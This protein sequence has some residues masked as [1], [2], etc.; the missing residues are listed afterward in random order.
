MTGI[1][2]QHL[3]SFAARFQTAGYA[4]LV[5]DN[6]NFGA[7]DGVPRFEVDA[8]K[9]IEDYHDAITFATSL[10]G[11]VDPSR[12]AL[13]GS[14]YSGGNVLQASAVDRR[15]KAVIAQV[16]FVS[17]NSNAPGIMP[18]M[19]A[20]MADRARIATGQAGELTT[21]VPET[22]EEAE[23]GGSLSILPTPDAY[24]FFVHSPLP[25]GVTWENKI[26]LQSLFK[27]LKNEP[28]AYVPR[29][30]PT[31]LLMVVAE[32][33]LAV[34]V[35][36]QLAVFGEAGEPKELLFMPKTG[37]FDVYSGPAFEVNIEKQ[38]EFLKQWLV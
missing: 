12:I 14:S 35:P 26:T 3:G 7:S 17:G 27:L 33:D 5:Y 1:K 10:A 4:A 6:R 38:L 34:H 16:P 9:Q 21:V 8:F 2:E 11:E 13:W 18:A 25:E 36:T 15:V 28:R 29:I 31:P 32:L 20:I 22:R 30:S 24:D 19:G 37:H 23:A